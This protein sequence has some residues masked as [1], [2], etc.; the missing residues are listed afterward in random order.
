MKELVGK[1][2]RGVI[3]YDPPTV[4]TSV[5]EIN[6]ELQE[7]EKLEG[8]FSVF[9][10]ND[11]KL[12]GIVY[13]TSEKV[14]L[15]N[16]KFTG[17]NSIINYFVNT[18]GC[19]NGTVING[20]FNVVTNGGEVVIPYHFTIRKDK[21]VSSDGEIENLFHFTN[22]VRT[23]YEEAIKIFYD[24]K[25]KRCLLKDNLQYQAL[26]EGLISSRSRENALEEFL[27]GIS[28]KQRVEFTVEDRVREYDSLENNYGD[29]ILISKDG[30][31]Y[32]EMTVSTEGAF[33]SDC[34]SHLTTEDFAGNHYEYRFSIDIDK[35]HDGMN[36]GKIIFMTPF[37]KIEIK[38]SV[39]NIHDQDIA[40]ME[41][42]IC[43]AK[44]SKMY[45]EFRMRR[46]SVNDWAEDSMQAIERVRGFDDSSNFI[47]LV[48]AQIYLSRS[49]DEQAGWLL[50]SVA[51]EILDER[52]KNVE[53]YSYYLYVRTLQKRN[54]DMTADV[55]RKVKHYYEN[56]YDSWRL[57]WILLYLDNS[58]ENNK[59][60]KIARIKEQYNHGCRSPLMYF[61]ALNAFSRQPVLLR[62]INDFELQVLVFGCKYEGINLRLA[63]Q[64][65]EIAMVEKKFR[66]LLFQVLT[67]L[68]ERFE[69]KE[70]LTAICS[71]LIRGNKSESKY[72][73]WFRLGIEADIKLARLYE[74]YIFSMDDTEEAVFP[75]KLLMYFAYNGHTLHEKQEILYSNIVSNKAAIPN[76][77]KNYEDTIEKFALD[78]IM[79]GRMNE[80]LSVIY[81]H[82][83][84]ESMVNEEI[85]KK[86][87]GIM[88]T[89]KV[90]CFNENICEVIVIHKEI[91][92]EEKYPVRNGQA[93]IRIYTEDPAIIFV[94]N[95]GKRYSKTIN[96]T[97]KHLYPEREYMK[98]C[99]KMQI[100]DRY[101]M[102][103]TSEKL[104]KY[105]NN[106]LRSVDIFKRIMA[107]D[108][109]RSSY[110]VMIIEDVIDYYYNN[111]DGDELDDYLRDIN[112][113]YLNA[114]TRVKV[115]EL[116]LL[117]GLDSEAARYIKE[118]GIDKISARRLVK[119]C[120]RRL[121]ENDFAWDKQLNDMCIYVFKKGKYSETILKYLCRYYNGTTK[122]M[123][124]IWKACQEFEYD[125]REYEERLIAQMLFTRTQL[126]S[127][128]DVYDSYYKNG[129]TEQIKKAF[130][131]YESYAYMIKETPI[132]EK[133]FQY[134]GM[135]LEKGDTLNEICEA[136]YVK[137][138]AEENASEETLQL[139]NRIIKHLVSKD[140]LFEFY[141]KY[142]KRIEL[143]GTIIENAIVEYRAKPEQK[144]EIHYMMTS[145]KETSQ[146]YRNEEMKEVFPGIYTKR[147]LL[148]YGENLMYYITE[149]SSSSQNLTESRNY[150]IDSDTF[151]SD[152]SRYSKLNEI[153][154]C[155]E[156]REES[157]IRDMMKSYY[158]EDMLVR[159]LF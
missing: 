154:V 157:T 99:A 54:P 53:L 35:L 124:E 18:D 51:E 65:S 47:K 83:L 90:E 152:E 129:V 117:R 147:I 113:E 36:Y 151:D 25:F 7:E 67:T 95:Y 84:R 139:C 23:K 150:Y 107:D 131:F 41:R 89:Y 27:I 11:S 61:E 46:K 66:P 21:I 12:K 70:I 102:A 109:F 96:Y 50:G 56:G 58:Y 19:E 44:L 103:D 149:E 59:S 125:A 45:L 10:E 20:S 63:M 98:L 30:W 130:L 1:L 5:A 140:I 97:L 42:K 158:V 17:K 145:G 48:Q 104:L 119:H 85:A 138:Y 32:A 118:T 127:I 72:F 28:K 22:L 74:Y 31:G 88:N 115:V 100:E 62:V 34:R 40:Y 75:E 155:K 108:A 16:D 68:Y 38:I 81:R 143:P 24:P 112:D 137:Y 94:D 49:M 135:E 3:E 141:K 121:V 57:L 93:Y 148:F 91:I 101:L 105:H 37:Q 87:I 159:Q 110:K 26:Y 69:N 64:I 2:S 126:S 6:R 123:L 136:A 142:Q 156:M 33:L 122:E 55:L 79:K 82:I 134:L 29:I 14:I 15:E 73:K 39:D 8:A 13:S 120:T 77:Y 4:E 71:M 111:Y 106:D 146:E 43:T 133:V 86:L 116:M 114:D 60:L 9:C 76:I 92:G 132:A 128:T 78:Q 80:H 153:L 144:V 52:E